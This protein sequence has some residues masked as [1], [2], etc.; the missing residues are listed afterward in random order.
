MRVVVV[1]LVLVV[2]LGGVVL[3]V[4][5]VVGVVVLEG[6]AAPVVLTAVLSRGPAPALVMT[7]TGDVRPLGVVVRGAAVLAAAGAGG[8]AGGEGGAGD[9][10][11]GG[12]A[13]QVSPEHISQ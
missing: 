5:Q 8:G 10:E 2:G 3:V 13:W 4:V 7:D 1:C 12:E 11:A 6:V 9:T